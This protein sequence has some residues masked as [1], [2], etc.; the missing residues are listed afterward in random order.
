M[1]RYVLRRGGEREKDGEREYVLLRMGERYLIGDRERG[2][3]LAG[4]GER[5]K[6]ARLREGDGESRFEGNWRC[7]GD[8]LRVGERE[9]DLRRAGERDTDLR[10]IEE[11]L[12]LRIDGDILRGGERFVRLRL[13][14]KERLGDRL[15]GFGM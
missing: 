8:L 6:E 12:C 2:R 5:K 1:L 3:A 4:D 7:T 13:G 14:L 9:S 10:R 11:R 15:L